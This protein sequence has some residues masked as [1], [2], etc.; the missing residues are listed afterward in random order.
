[1]LLWLLSL[2]PISYEKLVSFVFQLNVLFFFL[3]QVTDLGNLIGLYAEWHS[4]LL[5]Y[6]S[7]D[8]FVRKVERVGANNRVRVS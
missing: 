8:Q 7:F 3:V 1:M 6:F 4:R 2:F 5:P